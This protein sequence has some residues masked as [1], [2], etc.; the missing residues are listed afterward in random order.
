MGPADFTGHDKGH[1]VHKQLSAAPLLP[2][3]PGVW[4]LV[5]LSLEAHPQAEL[6]VPPGTMGPDTNGGRRS[7]EDPSPRRRLAAATSRRP[8]A[9]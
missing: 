3:T 4:S 5:L 8:T 7:L 6:Q 2:A 1:S 9:R